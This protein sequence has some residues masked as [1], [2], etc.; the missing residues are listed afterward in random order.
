MNMMPNMSKPLISP[1]SLRNEE[2]VSK[3]T[4]YNAAA[5]PTISDS[6]C[7]IDA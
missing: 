6:S 7:V 1:N 5:P 4:P 3:T 2:I